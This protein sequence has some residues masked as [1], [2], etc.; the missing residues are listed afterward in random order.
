MGRVGWP[1]M[2]VGVCFPE[3]AEPAG[4]VVPQPMSSVLQLQ[5]RSRK[6]I[7]DLFNFISLSMSKK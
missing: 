1:I 7:A 3:E 4:E 6:K 5:V 2:A